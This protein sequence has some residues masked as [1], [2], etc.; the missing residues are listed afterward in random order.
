MLAPNLANY[1]HIINLFHM[2]RLRYLLI[3]EVKYQIWQTTNNN[4]LFK[5]FIDL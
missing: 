3:Y 4:D 1:K 2:N 5:V